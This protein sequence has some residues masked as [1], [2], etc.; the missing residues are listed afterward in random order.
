M[1]NV[2]L[3]NHLLIEDM[4]KTYNAFLIHFTQKRTRAV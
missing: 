3:R 1:I 2:H 4:S